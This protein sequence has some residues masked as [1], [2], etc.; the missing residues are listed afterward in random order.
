MGHLLKE[1]FESLK[2]SL[3]NDFQGFEL[4]DE[5]RQIIGLVGECIDGFCAQGDTNNPSSYWE[6]LTT[7]YHQ[8]VELFTEHKDELL[9]AFQKGL[10]EHPSSN[11]RRGFFL[12][13]S[14]PSIP[15]SVSTELLGSTLANSKDAAQHVTGRV[16]K[17]AF[18][19]LVEYLIREI[20][21]PRIEYVSPT[22]DAVLTQPASF[23]S[24]SG[25]LPSSIISTTVQR[26]EISQRAPGYKPGRIQ[27]P[28]HYQYG[29]APTRKSRSSD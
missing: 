10:G 4:N 25:F 18:D 9:R 21:S 7:P 26:F 12:E 11:C 27:G 2:G 17:A 29:R 19:T 16:A 22:V 3:A 23:T 13:R 24:T 5:F 8:L 15:E 28:I 20:P 1:D 6:S 14:L